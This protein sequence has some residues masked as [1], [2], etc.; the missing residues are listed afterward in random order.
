M[1]VTVKIKQQFYKFL[2]S[3]GDCI[4][5]LQVGVRQWELRDNATC[6]MRGKVQHSSDSESPQVLLVAQ[7]F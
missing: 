4:V 3:H 2:L 5:N 6:F 1:A 7:N